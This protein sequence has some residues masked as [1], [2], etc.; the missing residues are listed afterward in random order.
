MNTVPTLHGTVW[1]LVQQNQT[2]LTIE[3]D[4]DNRES[5]GIVNVTNMTKQSFAIYNLQGVTITG[6]IEQLPKGVYVVEGRKVAVP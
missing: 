2:I 4:I 3:D 1:S 5:S 6:S